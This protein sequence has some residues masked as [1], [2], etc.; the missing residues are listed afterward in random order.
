MICKQNVITLEKR[1]NDLTNRYGVHENTQYHI[2]EAQKL[3]KEI[4]DML[5]CSVYTLSDDF[6]M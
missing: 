4:E 5:E 3:K 1:L 2:K 6:K